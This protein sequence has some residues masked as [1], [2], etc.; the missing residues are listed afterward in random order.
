MMNILPMI[1]VR[2]QSRDML[3]SKICKFTFGRIN[4]KIRNSTE[5]NAIQQGI[6]W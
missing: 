4:Y 2:N 5:K 3:D 6:Y 1:L